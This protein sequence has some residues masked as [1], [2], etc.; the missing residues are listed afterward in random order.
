[1][2]CQ[3]LERYENGIPIFKFKKKFN[4]LDDAIAQAKIINSGDFIIHKVVAYKC[5]LCLKYHLGRNGKELTD[6]QHQKYKNL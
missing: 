3:T 6:K 4:T 2:E 5:K 1:M